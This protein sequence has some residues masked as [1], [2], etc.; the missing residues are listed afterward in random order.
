MKNK[1]SVMFW[2][3]FVIAVVLLALGLLYLLPEKVLSC[4][5]TLMRK[6]AK[7]KLY[8]IGLSEGLEFAY[9][10]GGKSSG[11]VESIVLLH[12]FGGDKDIYVNFAKQLV[13]DYDIIIPDIIG[14]GDSSHPKDLNY[15]PI[16]QVKRLQQFCTALQLKSFHLLGN[17]MGGQLAT[18]YAKNFSSEVKSLV[19][20]APSGVWSADQTEIIQTIQRGKKNPLIAYSLAEYQEIMALGM[21]HP[22]KVPKVFLT[23]LAKERINNAD[24]EV[25]IFQALLDSNIEEDLTLLTLPILLLSGEEDKIISQES[26]KKLKVLLPHAKSEVILDAAHVPTYEEPKIAATLLKNFLKAL[27]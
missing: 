20:V 12:G 11:K 5:M 1:R 23:V 8:K 26:L 6:Q 4:L 16:E 2:L 15:A 13:N 27:A 25:E 21:K 10:R 9:L 24:V 17:S 18:L 7:L 19:L 14:F 3:S 22:P